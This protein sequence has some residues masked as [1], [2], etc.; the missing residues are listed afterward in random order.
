MRKILQNWSYSRLADNII[1]K[2]KERGI[3]AIRYNE[4]GTSSECHKC[5]GK[6]RVK[7][8]RVVCTECGMQYDREFNSCIR[9]LQKA[10]API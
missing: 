7:G 3:I 4:G 2:V 8:R 9:L 10:R 6:L 5:G 1:E